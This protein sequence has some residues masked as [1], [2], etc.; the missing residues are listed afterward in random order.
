M[1]VFPDEEPYAGGQTSIERCRRHIRGTSQLRLSQ[2]ERPREEVSNMGFVKTLFSKTGVLIMIYLVIGI[3]V[4]TAPP[5]VPSFGANL[6]ALHSWVQYF[7][8]IIFWPL[9]FWTPSFTVGKWQP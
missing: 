2:H 5:H 6:N 3:F 4:N 9:S 1:R 7:I 8:S